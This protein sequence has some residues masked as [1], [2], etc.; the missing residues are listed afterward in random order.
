MVM[1]APSIVAATLA[2]QTIG[3]C[4]NEDSERWLVLGR[5]A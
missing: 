2:V 4:D 1:G 5:L 3:Q